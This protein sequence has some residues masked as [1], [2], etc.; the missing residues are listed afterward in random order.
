M[1]ET[2]TTCGV[3]VVA[4]DPEITKPAPVYWDPGLER[5]PYVSTVYC[6]AVLVGA[7]FHMLEV[8]TWV[9]EVGVI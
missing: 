4:A 1:T 3:A 7:K 2:G 6:P 8:T 9:P 5:A